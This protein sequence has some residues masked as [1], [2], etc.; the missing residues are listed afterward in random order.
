[1][2]NS[3]SDRRREQRCAKNVG[4][5]C[6]LLNGNVDRLVTVRNFSETGLF[7]ETTVQIIPGAYIVLRSISADEAT[8]DFMTSAGPLYSLDFD[9]PDVCSL[10]RSH[11]VAR[12]QR[13]ELIGDYDESS[14]YG[15]A[16]EIQRLTD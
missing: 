15:V 10:F 16:A 14:R 1:M 7:F 6:T 8:D 13:C 12:V 2:V 9:D 11:T 4:M 3:D 5:H